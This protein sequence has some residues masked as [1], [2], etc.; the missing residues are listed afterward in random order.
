MSLDDQLTGP[1]RRLLDFGGRDVTLVNRTA[2]TDADGNV[3]RDEYRD[4]NWVED[5]TTVRAEKEVRGDPEFQVRAGG[6][7]IE[8]DA[9]FWIDSTLSVYTGDEGETQGPTLVED[10]GDE[11]RVREHFD[12]NNGKRRLHTTL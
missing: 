6:D 4:V 12:E 11:Y 1:A 8:A 7:D 9:L 3:I 10:D 2:E 5:R